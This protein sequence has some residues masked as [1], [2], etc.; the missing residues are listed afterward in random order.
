MHAP[1]CDDTS[2][3]IC[4]KT[5]AQARPVN[6]AAVIGSGTMG[7]GIAMCFAEAGIPVTLHDSSKEALDRAL[8]IQCLEMCFLD[9]HHLMHV[10]IFWPCTLIIVFVRSLLRCPAHRRR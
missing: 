5:G 1:C 4:K 10:M 8:V 6:S 9:A 2:F 3:P 7:A